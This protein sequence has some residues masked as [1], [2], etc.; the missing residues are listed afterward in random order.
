M[1]IGIL[2]CIV[3]RY[4]NQFEFCIDIKFKTF[5][6]KCLK[7]KINLIILD[8]NSNLKNINLI[9]LTGGN[10]LK[11]FNNKKENVIRYDL[12]KS[13]FKK[14]I[15]ENKKVLA[16]CY[17]SLFIADFFK[18]KISKTKLHI[19]KNHDI[20]I[21]NK[22]FSVNSFH[23]YK[24]TKIADNFKILAKAKDN[25]VEAFISKN[26]KILCTMWH[27]ERYS[28]PKKIEILLMKK[29]IKNYIIK[30]KSDIEK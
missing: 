1:N 9:V 17:G 14:A 19:C 29:F 16:I 12:T 24:I 7:K 13:I 23:N 3:S 5:F 18:S 2:P 28:S 21:F 27:P 8:K 22:K 20:L 26:K 25:S 4:K 10:D 30:I 11:K 15:K 6:E